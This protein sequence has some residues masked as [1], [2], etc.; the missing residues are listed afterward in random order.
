M[1]SVK[2]Y[3]SQQT[4]KMTY[5]SS[6]HSRMSYGIMFWGHS[7]S[8]I[9]VFRLQKMMIRIMMGC[10]S[11]DSCRKLFIKL[12]ILPLPSVHVFPSPIC[13]KK[14]KELFTTNH[15]I[16]SICTRQPLNFHQPP[17]NLTKYQ[18]GVYYMGLKIFNTLPAYIKQESDNHKK[19]ESLLK[20]LLYANSFYSLEE[21]YRLFKS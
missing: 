7:A 17:A 8:S 6:S 14:N 3:M 4:L 18:T 10:T 13:D 15:E 16:H 1:R 2:P 9:R 21:F 11:R 19:F 20:K 12:K 5:Y